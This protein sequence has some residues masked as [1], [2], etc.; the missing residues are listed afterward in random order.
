VCPVALVFLVAEMIREST[1]RRRI[2]LDGFELG[3]RELLV[4]VFIRIILVVEV[5]GLVIILD[6]VVAEFHMGEKK[7]QF[8]TGRYNKPP[9]VSSERLGVIDEISSWGVCGTSVLEGEVRQV[10]VRRSLLTFIR[11]VLRHLPRLNLFVKIAARET[12]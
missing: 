8:V 12:P 1:H 2:F 4:K 9:V 3:T 7:G 11:E 6:G 5:L 10:T